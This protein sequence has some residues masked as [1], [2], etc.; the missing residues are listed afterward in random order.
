MYFDVR[1]CALAPV[2]CYMVKVCYVLSN[3]LSHP[4]QKHHEKNRDVQASNSHRPHPV[5]LQYVDDMPHDRCL[6]LH[7]VERIHINLL[8]QPQEHDKCR[9]TRRCHHCAGELRSGAR[10]VQR[11]VHNPYCEDDGE[12]ETLHKR[13]ECPLFCLE[14]TVCSYLRNGVGE[15]NAKT[16]T[17]HIAAEDYEGSGPLREDDS[18]CHSTGVR[19]K[20]LEGLS[21]DAAYPPLIEAVL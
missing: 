16:C 5:R 10:H 11:T 14:F 2:L 8:G 21:I 1:Y 3:Q 4:I 12:Q 15:E 18:G 17:E 20:V 7:L 19:H 6:L 9:D 13:D